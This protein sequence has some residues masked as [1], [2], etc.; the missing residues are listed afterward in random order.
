MGFPTLG[1]QIY[2]VTGNGEGAANGGPA[3]GRTP[4]STLDQVVANFHVDPSTGS[5]SQT[6]Y[7]EPYEY[8]NLNA[9]D[10]DFGS[11]GSS[12]LDPTVF[13]GT[14]VQRII[15]AGGKRFVFLCHLICYQSEHFSLQICPQ[16][17]YTNILI[18]I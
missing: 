9:A 14:G 2:F 4:L 16:I 1:D 3:S 5:L 7:F 10:L 6:D 13:N 12:L 17:A 11:S 8:V 18:E 15:V